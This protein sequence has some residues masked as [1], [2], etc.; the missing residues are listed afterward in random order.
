MI[1]WMCREAVA[2]KPNQRTCSGV[3]S[4]R[5]TAHSQWSR[6]GTGALLPSNGISTTPTS[7]CTPRPPAAAVVAAAAAAALLL[8]L[9]LL[10]LRGWP[11][12][13]TA[14]NSSRSCRASSSSASAAGASG[15]ACWMRLRRQGSR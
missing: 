8:L 14:A 5:P 6:P 15:A 7:G 4:A 9:P 13:T 3:S 10:L 2:I 12:A 1:S 11:M